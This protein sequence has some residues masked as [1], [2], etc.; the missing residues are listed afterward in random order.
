MLDDQEM[1][2]L[3]DNDKFAPDYPLT[4]VESAAA[5]AAYWRDANVSLSKR[6][7]EISTYLKFFTP[8]ID[9]ELVNMGLLPYSCPRPC[10]KRHVRRR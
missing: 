1:N 6:S 8:N 2:T 4:Y 7:W 9:Q 10:S 5:Q 3:D